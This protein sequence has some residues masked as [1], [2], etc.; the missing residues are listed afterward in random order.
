MHFHIYSQKNTHIGVLKN[1]LIFYLPNKKLKGSYFKCNNIIQGF[2]K[3]KI[4]KN[5]IY[6]ST[7]GFKKDFYFKKDQ[8]N[9]NI[10]NKKTLTFIS[11]FCLLNLKILNFYLYPKYYYYNYLN[12][13]IKKKNYIYTYLKNKNRKNKFFF[14]SLFWNK[15]SNWK[16]FKNKNLFFNYNERIFVR[17][18]YKKILII[19]KLGIK[20]DYNIDFFQK[21]IFTGLVWILPKDSKLFFK[22][23]LLL[24][25]LLITYY[26]ALLVKIIKPK[27]L[28]FTILL[29]IYFYKYNIFKFFWF[30]K[31]NKIKIRKSN[32]FLRKYL[33]FLQKKYSMYINF[34]VN[35]L[36]YLYINKNIYTNLNFF[37][38]N[39]KLI[40]IN[41]FKN[42]KYLNIVLNNTTIFN[43]L[44][45]FNYLIT[46]L[47]LF[48][49][50]LNFFNKNLIY[51]LYLKS[52]LIFK[53]FNNLV[54]PLY[55]FSNM[56]IKNKYLLLFLLI[57]I[58][59]KYNEKLYNINILK[60]YNF[61]HKNK[62]K[63]TY[64]FK[65]QNKNFMNSIIH[66]FMYSIHKNKKTFYKKKKK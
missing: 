8:L 44:F 34:L 2:Y 30:L 42:K 63:K 21:Y 11:Y 3:D 33:H 16:N 14:Y 48:N 15:Y 32:R 29:Y 51:Y 43:K 40:L 62:K 25:N 41:N 23:I 53:N 37:I 9:N 6:I 46:I 50:K 17:N 65:V 4:L 47:Y 31:K 58:K 20:S 59:R 49:N 66:K 36:Y 28:I 38:F 10:L 7:C 57:Y 24:S 35:K 55:L 39:N 54:R 12:N 64:K 1:S 61:L 52:L 5:F 27:K 26:N 60:L 13:Y 22:Q 56:Y 19:N 18:N 45:I